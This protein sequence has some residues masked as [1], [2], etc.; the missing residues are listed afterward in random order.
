MLIPLGSE[1]TLSCMSSL[2]Y[3]HI[4][5]VLGITESPHICP[6][7]RYGFHAL[8]Y[9]STG[10]KGESRLYMEALGEQLCSAHK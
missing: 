10:Q 5:G 8:A 6:H 3:H 7:L 9:V 1:S 2:D 4:T